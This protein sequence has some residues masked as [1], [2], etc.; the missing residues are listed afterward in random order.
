LALCNNSG[1]ARV[2]GRP[3]SQPAAPRPDEKFKLFR[4]D[5]NE[6]SGLKKDGEI[7]DLMN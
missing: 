4:E 6:I 1:K 5:G 2:K 7:C 3:A